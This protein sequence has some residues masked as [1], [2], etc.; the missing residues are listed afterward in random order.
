MIN[1]KAAFAHNISS[2]PPL[3][4]AGSTEAAKYNV[5]L[6]E[7]KEGAFRHASCP[8]SACDLLTICRATSVGSMQ[9]KSNR[10]T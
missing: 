1:G 4:T 10:T 9:I 7:Q 8:G 6:L 3:I 5:G 2:G